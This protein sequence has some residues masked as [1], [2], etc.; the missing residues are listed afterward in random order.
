MW[1]DEAEL[2]DACRRLRDL[3][4]RIDALVVGHL[5][6]CAANHVAGSAG[7][8]DE[9][10]ARIRRIAAGADGESLRAMSEWAAGVVALER[11][12]LIQ[13]PGNMGDSGYRDFMEA[14]GKP[15]HAVVY[16][17][18]ES[19]QSKQQ[20]RPVQLLD[21]PVD[22]AVPIVDAVAELFGE[23]PIGFPWLKML[24]H[25]DQGTIAWVSAESKESD[26]EG[27]EREEEHRKGGIGGGVGGV[28]SG[29]EL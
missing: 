16:Q 18:V 2:R 6:E 13:Q 19:P 14:E 5:R 4:R 3:H 20:R 21:F 8:H 27:G 28:G 1:W 11:G 23:H 7:G 17:M 22:D 26:S 24:T 25:H 9:K 29:P 15:P 12:P 10:V